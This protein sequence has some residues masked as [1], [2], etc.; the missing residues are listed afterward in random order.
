MRKTRQFSGVSFSILSL[1]ILLVSD[2]ALRPTV[3]LALISQHF[4][5]LERQP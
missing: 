2:L 5:F 1:A 3:S 4:L